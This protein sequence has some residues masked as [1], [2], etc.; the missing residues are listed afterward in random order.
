VDRGR[1]E[2]NRQQDRRL[3][4][5]DSV[6]NTTL[7]TEVIGQ[8]VTTLLA[9]PL[10]ALLVSFA[11]LRLYRRAVLKSMRNRTSPRAPVRSETPGRTARTEPT[12]LEHAPATA[13]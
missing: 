9:A 4:R 2:E 1:K 12:M 13:T 8:L 7:T 5:I 11:L 10:L 3:R 6:M